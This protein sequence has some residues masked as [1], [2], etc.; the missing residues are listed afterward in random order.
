MTKNKQS[1]GSFYKVR[2]LI[3]VLEKCN[4]KTTLGDSNALISPKAIKILM[5]IGLLL[6]T[7]AL[8]TGCYFLYPLIAPIIPLRN[9]T[10]T[11]MLIVMLI[12]FILAVKNLVTVLYT[13][14]DLPVLL[15]MPFSAG[16]IV[17]AKLGNDAGI[18]GAAN[19]Y[20]NAQ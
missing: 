18:I 4:G 19:L 10:D 6:L 5:Y 17:T 20:L 7:G 13:A 16:Q 8:F 12:S 2:R 3:T 11:L 1:T 14:D 15:P 9:I